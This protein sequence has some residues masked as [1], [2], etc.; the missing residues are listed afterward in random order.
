MYLKIFIFGL[1]LL[2]AGCGQTNQSV[3]KENITVSILP[4]KF[5]VDKIGGGDFNVNVMV[6]PGASPETFE[7]TA[8][9]MKELAKSKTYF[10]FDLL[11]FEIANKVKIKENFKDVDYV[12][13]SDSMAVA[14]HKH[15]DCGH[16]HGVD[17]HVWLSFENAKI[18]VRNICKRLIELKPENKNAY[19]QQ[20]ENLIDSIN[21]LKCFADL[22]IQK[23]RAFLIYHPSLSYFADEM[24]IK[25]I[26]IENDG[27]EPSVANIKSLINNSLQ[28]SI[29][30]LLY[31]K[32]FGSHVVNV[33]KNELNI[34]PEVF[35]PLEYEWF[36]NMRRIINLLSK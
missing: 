36:V 9:Q 16:H 26:A 6:P 17:P 22:K 18:M 30:V 28:D 12:N 3:E 32:Q 35:D 14:Q 13:L 31:Q 8:L 34:T 5:F 15:S 23:G 2:L 25:Q 11:D 21:Q 7:P 27:K 29:K 1:M 10:S 4:I 24:K 19:I 33:I 20:A